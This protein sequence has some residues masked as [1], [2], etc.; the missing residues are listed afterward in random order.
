MDRTIAEAAI[1]Y[2]CDINKTE[3]AI[4]I[5]FYGGECMLHFALLRNIMAF[6]QKAHGD[7][8]FQYHFD[9]NGTL[10]CPEHIECFLEYD[11]FVQVSIDGPRTLHDRFRV[12]RRGRGTYDRVIAGLRMIREADPD[13]YRTRVRFSVTISPPYDLQ[14]IDR[15]LADDLFADHVVAARFVDPV[16]TSFYERFES[17]SDRRHYRDEISALRSGFIDAL[18]GGARPSPLAANFLE[19]PLFRIHRRGR[20]PEGSELPSN[21]CC[22]PGCRK[23][24]V[25]VHGDFRPCERVGQAF[26]I[27]NIRDGLD[28]DRMRALASDY[29]DMSSDDC[30]TCWAARLCA[31]CFASAR[32]GGALDIERKREACSSQRATLMDA[33]ITYVSILERNPNAL[34]YVKNVVFS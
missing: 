22:V 19:R 32:R 12:T 14:A 8:H 16:D 26:V 11:T 17:A 29:V 31:L 10:M 30:A 33:L 15:L 23:L 13:Y 27:G 25:D 3:D 6:S 34:D 18:V 2:L 24:F 20:T 5:S 28:L 1:R 4:N 21:G 7:R 9:T